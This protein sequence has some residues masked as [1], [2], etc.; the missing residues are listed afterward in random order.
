MAVITAPVKGF[1]GPGVGGLVFQDGRA[2]TDHPAVIAYARRHGYGVEDEPPH[3]PPSG[4]GRPDAAERPARSASKAEWV[5]YAD[6]QDPGDHEAM[7]K[8]QLIDTYGG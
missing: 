8:E 7:T 1:T 3:A 6:R 2:E 4:D 5:A